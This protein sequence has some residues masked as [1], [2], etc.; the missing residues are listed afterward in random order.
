MK[1]IFISYA[2]ADAPAADSIAAALR[3]AGFEVWIDSTGIEAG[4][5][6][7]REIE[8]AL[9]DA[10]CAI[11]LWSLTSVES[12]WVRNE[13]AEAHRGGK[14]IPLLID[15]AQPPLQF[16]SVQAI[17]FRDW[18]GTVQSPQFRQ[19]KSAIERRMTGEPSPSAAHPP[20]VQLNL[21][22]FR[23]TLERLGL[24]FA[25]RHT[26]RRFGAFFNDRYMTQ[27][28]MYLLVT[29]ALY[30]VYAIV[31]FIGAKST[32]S[33]ELFQFVATPVLIVAFLISLWPPIQRRWRAAV[34]LYGLFGVTVI[35][36]GLRKIEMSATGATGGSV[37]GPALI[38]IL[39]FVGVAP[40]RFPE[41]VIM[42]FVPLYF[43]LQVTPLFGF[44]PSD[45]QAQLEILVGVY[46][47]M[48]VGA[49]WRER[50]A[51]RWFLEVAGPRS[52]SHR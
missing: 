30:C 4:R 26:E 43:G 21:S 14:L 49:W 32:G 33:T 34:L 38:A 37:V 7:D 41:T 17:D 28:R 35:I 24:A 44:L 23:L 39:A 40:V 1:Q 51:R 22:T 36:L 47:M 19:L 9:R 46:V 10:T 27:T 18:D 25:D 11:V 29:A 45:P 13:A 15:A 5:S 42:C 2:R 12:E 52:P 31:D 20:T 8:A 48:V 3:A 16:K 6:F 50:N